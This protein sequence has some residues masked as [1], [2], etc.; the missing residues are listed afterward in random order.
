M[1]YF[2][3]FGHLISSKS[4]EEL[5]VFA[6]KIGLKREWFQNKGKLSHYDLCRRD[7]ETRQFVPSIYMMDKAR[8]AGAKEISPKALCR[9]LYEAPEAEAIREYPLNEAA[10]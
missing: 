8:K 9:I 3:R 1:I 6:Q 10:S 4:L 5:H 2:D 7:P